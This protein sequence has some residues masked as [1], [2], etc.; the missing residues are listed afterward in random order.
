V[1]DVAAALFGDSKFVADFGFELI[2][3]AAHFGGVDVAPEGEAVAIEGF[4]GTDI[5]AAV[6]L[7]RLEDVETAIQKIGDEGFDV[8][9]GVEPEGDILFVK[10]FAKLQEEGL[11]D[12]APGVRGE[13]QSAGAGE[14]IDEIEAVGF[15]AEFEAMGEAIQ[16][17][18]DVGLR[19]VA[20]PVG[21]QEEVHEEGFISA[22]PP[23][24][25][26]GAVGDE[27]EVSVVLADFLVLFCY[28]GPGG[29]LIHVEEVGF[30]IEAGGVVG[31]EA[32]AG[33]YLL[34]NG[35]IFGEVV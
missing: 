4:E 11:V 10:E 27:E 20:D 28:F 25:F 7:E 5:H 14:I 22:V 19:H 16:E 3:G 31:I 13:E 17:E 33:F 35:F 9:A 2:G 26:P 32:E 15:H 34:P 24:G 12:F 1:E 8:S 29:I 30:V 18:I 6:G 23:G 21:I